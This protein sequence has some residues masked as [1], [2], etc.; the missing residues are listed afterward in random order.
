MNH[1]LLTGV[2]ALLVAG[3]GSLHAQ[4]PT[5]TG[6]KPTTA[7]GIVATDTLIIEWYRPVGTV[8]SS[9]DVNAAKAV[10][11]KSDLYKAD[12]GMISPDSAKIVA[13][14]AVPGQIGSGEMNVDNGVTEYAIDIIP[15]GKK[16][17][18]KVIVDANTG[19][20]LSSKQFGGLRG[21]AGWVRESKEHKQ[22]TVKPPADTTTVMSKTTI[23]VTK[24]SVMKK[25]TT[26][27][28]PPTT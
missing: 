1:K 9:V 17:H 12:A 16:T 20:V 11:I 4:V 21:L 26:T 25:D 5:D 8:C 28:Q 23:T 6:K 22:N 24:D 18:T 27:R 19:A 10:E 13:L 7:A 14:C 2:A 3:A 15:N